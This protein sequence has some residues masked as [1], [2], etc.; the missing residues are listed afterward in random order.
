MKGLKTNYLTIDRYDCIV[1]T[2]VIEPNPNWR[3][4]ILKNATI[5]F[6]EDG[7]VLINGDKIL[8]ELTIERYYLDSKEI[9]DIDKRD[10]SYG[11]KSLLDLIKRRKTPFVRGWHRLTKTEPYQCELSKYFIELN[12]ELL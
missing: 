4:I 8:W 2:S 10:I 3:L 12:K 5:T 9:L 11:Y 7:T 1:E 6:F